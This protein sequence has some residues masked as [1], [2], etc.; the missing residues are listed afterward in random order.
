MESLLPLPVL[1][2]HLSFQTFQSNDKDNSDGGH[3]NPE[4]S[5]DKALHIY[6]DVF[7]ENIQDIMLLFFLILLICR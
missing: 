6:H 7:M 4:N 1:V 5:F 3:C 2:C